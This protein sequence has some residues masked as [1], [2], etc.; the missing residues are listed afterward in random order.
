MTADFSAHKERA[1]AE[2]RAQQDEV[3]M[4]QVLLQ[5]Q[6]AEAEQRHEAALSE[7][8]R[9]IME[10]QKQQ[11]LA[12]EHK[13]AAAVV[14]VKEEHQEATQ[15]LSEARAKEEAEAACA[16]ADEK[17][18]AVELQMQE[19]LEKT[20]R[21]HATEI[22]ELKQKLKQAEALVEQERRA[23][24]AQPPDSGSTA[25]EGDVEPVKTT[26][27]TVGETDHDVLGDNEV[28]NSRGVD[29]KVVSDGDASDSSDEE[30]MIPLPAATKQRSTATTN[31]S[32]QTTTS[33]QA[34]VNRAD[35]LAIRDLIV[36]A[37]QAQA[38]PEEGDT[39]HALAPTGEAFTDRLAVAQAYATA[40]MAAKHRGPSAEVT[41][42]LDTLANEQQEGFKA[43]L[44]IAEQQA[45]SLDDIREQ[46]VA[47][48][49]AAD[50]RVAKS[51][52]GA[53]NA[54]AEH[55]QSTAAIRERLTAISEAIEKLAAAA[56]ANSDTDGGGGAA[57]GAG[58]T[59]PTPMEAMAAQIND[60]YTLT[61]IVAERQHQARPGNCCTIQ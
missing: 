10:H 20:R 49:V 46:L 37:A 30:D 57:A 4:C 2:L 1:A 59:K 48:A 24:K 50:D 6:Q 61:E 41:Q 9:I 58:E 31:A 21:D 25:Q 15:A 16:A 8:E 17:V 47:L 29:C 42:Q 55:E 33:L 45:I 13:L 12:F 23:I 60:L 5:E 38:D 52:I 51:E 14:A 56:A 7:A 32:E 18:K 27:E 34:E 39:S 11:E 19:A 3:H 44:S 35:L 28:D 36:S 22:A 53:Q 26:A 43:Q 54:L 40:T